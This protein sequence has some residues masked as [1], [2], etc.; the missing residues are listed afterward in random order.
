M[1]ESIHHEAEL[2]AAAA[3]TGGLSE[4][5]R[6][7]WSGHIAAC[8]ACK[9]LNE[10]E[11][12]M[13]H[14]IKK[15]LHPAFPSPGFEQRIILSIRQSRVGFG[16]RWREFVLFHPALVSA[17]ACVALL[18]IVG[19]GLLIHGK[20]AAAVTSAFPAMFD[21]L[22][23]AVRN[24]IQSQFGGNTVSKIER[25]EEDGEIS[26]TLETK[27]SDGRNWDLTVAENG[28]L[29]SI[30]ATLTTVPESV[31]N[32]INA[33]L[34]QSRLGKIEVS[35]RDDEATYV[36]SVIAPNGHERDLTF[37]KDGMLTDIET[38]LTELPA[39]VKAAINAQAGQGGL[40][41]VHK[42]FDDDETTYLATIT[43][44]DG[45][46]RDFS[47]RED[48]S[49]SSMETTLAELP[50]AVRA[51]VNTQAARGKLDGID[52]VYD[53]S[54]VT[55]QVSVINQD[56]RRRDFSLSEHGKLLTREVAMSETPDPVRQTILR[57]VGNGRVIQ[58]DQSY[59]ESN[60]GKPFEI[61]GRK[62]GTPFYF[63][64]SPTGDF[65]GMEN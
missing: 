39:P 62:D 2:W 32:A 22:P 55:Y 40:E 29:L 16:N 28:T 23:A 45:S 64:V 54:K 61:E 15:S 44:R 36:V 24:A 13:G 38:P 60:N 42:R 10:E 21:E 35:L 34:G 11:I 33:Q 12:A 50:A 53:E 65:L 4:T 57:T 63:L 6:E 25:N 19:A 7:A 27:T 14:L 17:A 37:S 30:D 3:A 47:F 1:N 48:G 58:I 8:P 31:R 5:E 18:A 43:A 56:G 9:K 59:T 20:K 49:L 46:P 52:M 51:A 26:Y 41:E